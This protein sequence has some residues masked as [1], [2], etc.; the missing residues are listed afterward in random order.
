MKKRVTVDLT[1]EEYQKL[2]VLKRT[3]DRPLAW[4][5]RKAILE[6]LRHNDISYSLQK[7]KNNNEFL[8]GQI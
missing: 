2:L 5:G 1:E 6:F 4:I 8:E 7:S 3:L